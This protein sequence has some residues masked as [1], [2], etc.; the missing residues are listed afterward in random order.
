[1]GDDP[2]RLLDDLEQ[3]SFPSTSRFLASA[4]RLSLVTSLVASR[5]M[6]GWARGGQVV[7]ITPTRTRGST[8]VRA[9]N[10]VSSSEDG[11]RQSLV[12]AYLSP[13]AFSARTDSRE[14][15]ELTTSSSVNRIGCRLLFRSR[16]IVRT[17]SLSSSRSGPVARAAILGQPGSSR[18]MTDCYQLH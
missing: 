4:P 14:I 5:T 2:N 15:V 16:W 13:H 10:V 17:R 3:I 12:M 1:M 8:V 11:L 7:G 6:S 18:V 9:S